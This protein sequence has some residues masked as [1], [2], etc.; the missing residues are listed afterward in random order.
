MA[1][2]RPKKD[3]MVDVTLKRKAPKSQLAQFKAQATA[4]D[5]RAP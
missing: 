2:R 3:R 5:Y 4:Q 1:A